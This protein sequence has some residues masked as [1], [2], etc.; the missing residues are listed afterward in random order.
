MEICQ[1]VSYH[2]THLGTLTTLSADRR[3]NFFCLTLCSRA[4]SS[5]LKD[6]F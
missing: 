4:L 5:K 6:I 3:N 1:R 2:H